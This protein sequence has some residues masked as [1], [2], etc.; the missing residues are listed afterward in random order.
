M[1][2][3]RDFRRQRSTSN[4]VHKLLGNGNLFLIVTIRN[5]DIHLG[6]HAGGKGSYRHSLC[7]QKIHGDA[8]RLVDGK[9]WAH[10]IG[11]DGNLFGIDNLASTNDGGENDINLGAG[12]HNDRLEL[13]S[14]DFDGDFFAVVNVDLLLWIGN[15]HLQQTAV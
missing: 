2:E 3:V 11:L 7:V 6:T 5:G 14:G 1:V 10:A 12:I 9:D 4:F 13:G 8:N 15:L